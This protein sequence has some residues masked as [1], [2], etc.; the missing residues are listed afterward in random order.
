[1]ISLIVPV[2]NCENVVDNSLDS[3]FSQT[4]SENQYEIIAINDGSTD[5]T[6]DI[7]NRYQDRIRIISQ[8]NQGLPRAANRAISEAKYSYI[9][10]LDPDDYYDKELLSSTLSILES[11]PDYDCVYS[12]RYEVNAYEKTQVKVEVG[13]NNIF[14]MISCG[15]LIRREVFN[16][17]GLYR[18]LLFEEYDLMLRFFYGGLRSYYLQKPLY[19]YV[20]H[21]ANMTSQ[22]SY[23]SE[24]WKQLID[25][26]GHESLK[27][28]VDIHAKINGESRFQE[29]ME[30]EK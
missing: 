22:D 2:Y 5:N 28:Y 9:M 17:I 23:W 25:I 26:W 24:G 14:D 3:I 12:D 16:K 29:L 18:D 1:M 11:L 19:Y 30:Q 27:K 7:L 15:V 20:R 4:L 6:L 13:K 8:S 21:G 10:R